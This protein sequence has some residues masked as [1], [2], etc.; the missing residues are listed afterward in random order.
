MDEERLARLEAAIGQ[1]V[2]VVQQLC[3]KMDAIDEEVDKLASN[4]IVDRLNG[5][6][7]EFGSM[8]GG[9]GDIIDGR[10]RREYDECFRSSHPEF[11]R[12]A[13]IGKRF[14]LDVYGLA[15]D[16]TYSAPEEEREKI[17]ADMLDELK[18]KFDDLVSALETHN[19]HE[20]AETPEEEKAEQMDDGSKPELQIE[21]AT[22]DDGEEKDPKIADFARIARKYRGRAVG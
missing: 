8:V 10:K 3:E 7:S 20:A 2:D 11:G 6:E 1:I 16:T 22:G 14:G 15:S 13:D 17:I 4:K 12:Y 21:V 18:S 19:A 9:L 5:I